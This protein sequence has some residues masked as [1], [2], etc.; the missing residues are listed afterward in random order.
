MDALGLY[1]MEGK[2]I[3]EAFISPFTC[4]TLDIYSHK[5]H[6]S[7]SNE[8]KNG[9]FVISLNL[10]IFFKSP[11]LS[12][13]IKPNI[14]STGLEKIRQSLDLYLYT[15]RKFYAIIKNIF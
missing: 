13:A 7:K 2:G 15:C 5:S 3:F 6:V 9:I 1:F 4:R 14:N 12:L 10:A 11:S 8:L